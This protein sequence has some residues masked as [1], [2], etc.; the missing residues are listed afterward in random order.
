[1]RRA[2][3]SRL[4]AEGLTRGEPAA[5]GP[6]R[7]AEQSW[8][9]RRSPLAEPERKRAHAWRGPSL[10]L[11]SLLVVACAAPARSGSSP[12]STSPELPPEAASA[13]VSSPVVSGPLVS[14]PSRAPALGVADVAAS[15]EQSPPAAANAEPLGEPGLALPHLFAAFRELELGRRDAHVRIAWFGDSH[16]AADFM[17]DAV[18]RALAARFGSGGPGLVLVGVRSSRHAHARMQLQGRWRR[19]PTTPAEPT[20]GGFFGLAGIG[21]A[22]LD[23]TSRVTVALDRDAAWARGALRW[24]FVYRAAPGAEMRLWGAGVDERLA[25]RSDRLCPSGLSRLVVH[26]SGQPRLELGDVVGEPELLGAFVETAAP[27]VV[28]DT[29]GINGARATTALAWEAVPWVEELRA[30]QPSMV[31]FAYGTNEVDDAT[32]PERYAAVYAELVGRVRR[33]GP[34]DC[35]ILGPIER[36]DAGFVTEPRVL[37]IEAA[38][39]SAARALS[40]EFF[41]LIEAMGGPGSFERWLSAV[42]PLARKDRVHLAPAGYD[43]LGGILATR[44]L[45]SYASLHPPQSSPSP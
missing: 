3:R 4:R 30:R 38:Q 5:S 18:R 23:K 22:P 15:A 6:C 21:A 45:S 16:T 40:C 14:E 26:T 42:P 28:L 35:L 24:E 13:V 34:A 33:A 1:M 25:A 37:A 17:T 31:V 29:L 9:G 44:I 10:L 20:T 41:S 2:Q 19:I 39:R 8:P 43:K 36:V 11:L 32:D 27:G 12:A 7:R